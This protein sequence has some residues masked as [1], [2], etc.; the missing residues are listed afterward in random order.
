MFRSLVA[1]ATL[2]ALLACPFRCAAGACGDA[3][4]EATHCPCCPVSP[5]DC[6]DDGPQPNGDDCG[7]QG[8]CGG[9]VL[10]DSPDLDGVAAHVGLSTAFFEESL[11]KLGACRPVTYAVSESPPGF[12]SGAALRVL[13]SSLLN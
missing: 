3:G 4:S 2:C 6:G 12:V 10:S 1:A 8:I 7:C 11:P 5:A 13:L 9:A